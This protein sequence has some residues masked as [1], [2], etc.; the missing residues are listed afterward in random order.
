MCK[1]A[2][3][4][5]T[6]VCALAVLIGFNPNVSVSA[7]STNSLDNLNNEYVKN[8][9]T[10]TY[11]YSIEQED[12]GTLY[13]TIDV[14]EVLTIGTDSNVSVNSLVTASSSLYA[15]NLTYTGAYVNG[16]GVTVYNLT[17]TATFYWN[18]TYSSTYTTS[19][20]KYIVN[21]TIYYESTTFNVELEIGCSKYGDPYYYYV[22]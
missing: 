22:N 6:L 13:V 2:K 5:L 17:S 10:G 16:L 11:D 14:G 4:I 9:D 1:K 3:M 18:N 12:G 7:E 21:A 20:S 8:L 15:R 19:I